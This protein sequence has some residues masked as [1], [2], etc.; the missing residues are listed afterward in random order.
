[1]LI[2][3]SGTTG[4]PKG[5]MLTHE[6]LLISAKDHGAFPKDGRQRQG[7]CRA[8]DLAYRRHLASDHD[9]DGRRHGPPGQQIRSRGTRQGDRRGGITILNGVPATYQRLL[10]YKTRGR[11]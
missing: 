1:V 7:L 6:N 8:A 4:T 10:E 11:V 5:V 9:P 3:T 2:Y